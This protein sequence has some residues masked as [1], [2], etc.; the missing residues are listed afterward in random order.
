MNTQQWLRHAGWMAAVVGVLA[1]GRMLHAQ[2]DELPQPAEPAAPAQAAEPTP[3]V[4]PTPPKPPRR[5]RYWLGLGC[6]PVDTQRRAELKLEAQHGLE[7]GDIVPES[8]AAMAALKPGDVILEAAG[9]PMS[10]VAQLIEA[11][12]ATEGKPL[13]LFIWSD[14]QARNVEVTPA[15]R[16][17]PRRGPGPGGPHAP[18]PEG[19]GRFLEHLPGGV[20][21][22][23]FFG[24][25]DGH[26]RF[27]W[28]FG[29]GVVL[30][31]EKFPDDLHIKIEKHGNQPAKVEV[32]RGDQKWEL[33]EEDL[34][35]LPEEIRPHL[36]RMLGRSPL[37]L[38]HWNEEEIEENVRRGID[39]GARHG[40]DW[41]RDHAERARD[42]ADRL[43]RQYGDRARDE[44]ERAADEFGRRARDWERALR[45]RLERMRP[46]HAPEHDSPAG[47]GPHPDGPPRP[48]APPRPE[49]PPPGAGPDGPDPLAGLDR[50]IDEQIRRRL[51]K[52]LADLHKRLDDLLERLPKSETKPDIKPGSE[53]DSDGP[54]I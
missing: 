42:E 12:D 49:G 7:I 52:P 34:Q 32:Q 53:G 13:T 54:R 19:W 17:A 16:P 47:D 8:P 46:P 14:G 29:P 22:G 37:L 9:K 25:P 45:R 5:A 4:E 41:A 26:R 48:D 44:A 2:Q 20:E 36:E 50:M 15:E 11:V 33:T 39:E 23:E 18:R 3:P 24:G 38:G 43:A 31:G 10:D 27:M 1:S 6:V 28:R 35:K 40:A 30:G 51:E 21:L